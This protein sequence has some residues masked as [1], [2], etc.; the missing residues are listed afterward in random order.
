MDDAPT[1]PAPAPT[2][3]RRRLHALR[4]ALGALLSLV[5]LGVALLGAATWALRSESGSAW[6]VALLPGVQV[7]A[8]R[9]RL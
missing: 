7:E 8:P 1:P 4:I 3:A 9:G 2:E 6:L 5:V